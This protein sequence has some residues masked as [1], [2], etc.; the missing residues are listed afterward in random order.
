MQPLFAPPLP[1]VVGHRGAPVDAPGNTPAS[2]AAA[3]AAGARWVELDARLSAD[4]TVVVHHDP[5]LADGRAIVDLDVEACRDA[6]LAT[7]AEVLV[8]LPPE[9]GVDV[10]IKNLPG[11]PDHDPEM[12]VVDAC[13]RLLADHPSVR[14]AGR[15]VVVSSFNPMVLVAL[16]ERDDHHPRALVTMWTAFPIGLDTAVELGAAGLFCHDSTDGLDRDGVDAA[17]DAGLEVMVWTVDDPG[18]TL[19]LAGIGVDA[20]CTDDPRGVL[21]TLDARL[22]PRG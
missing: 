17:H 10:E 8:G 3:A 19:E 21:A 11:D 9:I 5:V 20:I 15:P 13:S 22:R 6:G 4:G 16:A 14:V 2:F 12:A 18:R 1:V 7:L